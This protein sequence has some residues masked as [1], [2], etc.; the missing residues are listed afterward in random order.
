MKQQLNA[1]D[2]GYDWNRELATCQPRILQMGA[3][4]LIQLCMKGLVYKKE[5][6]TVNWDP[7]IKPS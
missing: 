4:V 3:V 7:V 5:S 1:L 2:I 6:S